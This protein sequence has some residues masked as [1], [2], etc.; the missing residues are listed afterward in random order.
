MIELLKLIMHL[1]GLVYKKDL[2]LSMS[3]ELHN[4]SSKLNYIL[5]KGFI[6]IIEKERYNT[7]HDMVRIT[8]EGIHYIAEKENTTVYE[9]LQNFPPQLASYTSKSINKSMEANRARIAMLICGV[10]VFPKDKPS[11]SY[12]CSKLAHPNSNC[13]GKQGYLDS[14]DHDE[15][16]DILDDTGVFY[17][18][19]EFREY[20]REEIDSDDTTFLSKFA[21][22]F[23][24]QDKIL[25]VFL[26]SPAENKTIYFET[27]SMKSIIKSLKETFQDITT[28]Y[29][30]LSSFGPK[31]VSN[32]VF[33]PEN[34]QFA[35]EPYALI[36]S[37][38]YEKVY[39]SVIG[40]KYGK[41]EAGT[42][43]D[44]YDQREDARR[45]GKR[46]HGKS[47]STHYFL[48][49]DLNEDKRIFR[50]TFV[51]PFSSEGMR[52]LNYLLSTSVE[53]WY[54]T[55]KD[56]FSYKPF[57]CGEDNEIYDQLFPGRDTSFSRASSIYMPVPELNVL[58]KIHSEEG[59]YS[60]LTYDFLI[61]PLS[62][63]VRNPNVKF[64]NLKNLIKLSDGGFK[65]TFE[66]VNNGLYAK[67]G[68]YAGRDDLEVYLK[69]NQ[70][71]YTDNECRK[72][73]TLFSL[74]ASEFWNKVH[75]KEITFGQ[76]TKKLPPHE[77]KKKKIYR[78]RKTDKYISVGP[79]SEEYYK[80]IK[81][82]CSMKGISVHYFINSTLFTA[83]KD[84]LTDAFPSSA[85]VEPS[86]KEKVKI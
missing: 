70:L 35:S 46:R 64:Y 14:L 12:L 9:L 3:F 83:L 41:L 11:F 79:F 43:K 34:W 38:G 45:K 30:S 7:A 26:E 49:A 86:S 75:S 23:I 51:C 36:I 65:P 25:I 44:G 61:E 20:S 10:P 48:K 1:N 66:E 22:V 16:K 8:K 67:S 27:K 15:I 85:E 56:Y 33:V 57:A 40:K 47:I 53:E 4:A 18:N 71:Q 76:I 77:L 2:L 13:E 68:L 62:R 84:V 54:E 50:R 6:E 19:K 80:Y 63:S 52:M 39:A 82:Y 21:G 58:R 31:K 81:R 28:A 60:I 55:S 5:K 69:K 72:L 29:R 42:S 32:D 78:R 24:K 37:N 59:H 73:P 17:S 74:P